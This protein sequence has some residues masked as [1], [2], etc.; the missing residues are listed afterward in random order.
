[1]MQ[2]TPPRT[3]TLSG[4]KFLQ[5]LA[6]Q[7]RSGSYLEIGPLFGSSTRAIAAGRSDAAVPIHTIDTFAPAPWIRKRLGMEL[8]RA[9]FDSYNGDLENLHVHEGFAPDVVRQH[10]REPIGFYFDDATHGDPGWSANYNFFAPFFTDDTIVCGDDFASGWPD[11]VRNVYRI[12]AELGAKLFVIG[13]VWAFALGNEARLCAA[14]HAAFPRLRG[15][16]LTVT[17]QGRAHHNIAASWSWGLHQPAALSAFQLHGPDGFGI[18]ARID[19]QDGTYT[20]ATLG[21]ETVDLGGATGLALDLPE[22]FGAQF[23]ILEPDGKTHNSRELRQIRLD[24]GRR[25]AAV[26]LTHA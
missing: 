26:R 4:L 24:E 7:R 8:S 18:E 15:F 13:R 10:W 9:A 6:A 1:M 22:G 3:M 11:I 19:R 12:S 2:P 21:R 25:L 5:A 14:A 17:H 20:T 23:C 16:D